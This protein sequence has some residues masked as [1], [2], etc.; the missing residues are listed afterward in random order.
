MLFSLW[1][2]KIFDPSPSQS[3]KALLFS[4]HVNVNATMVLEK[5]DLVERVLVLV[6][7]E[8]AVRERARRANEEEE[9]MFREQMR[10]SMQQEVE[11][12]RTEQHEHGHEHEDEEGV[13]DHNKEEREGA[14]SPHLHTGSSSSPPLRPASVAGRS[15]PGKTSYTDRNG[16]CVVCQDDE[17]NIAIVDCGHL[18]M[19]R[20]CSDLVMASSRECPLCRT[21]IVTE[22]RLLRI[23]KT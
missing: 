10:E 1:N 13:A 8:K 11:G 9:E 15:P 18:A 6:E 2:Q 22:A 17:A 7:N 12:E 4:N 3:L 5:S 21:R 20:E 16:L 19:C 14:S 23:F